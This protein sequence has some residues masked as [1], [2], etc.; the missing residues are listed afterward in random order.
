MKNSR[1]KKILI[2]I[3]ST[4]VIIIASFCIYE[5][6]TWNKEYYKNE[7]NIAIPIFIY[8]DIV[9][10][11]SDVAYDYMQTTKKV[12][13]EQISGLLKWGY[14]VIDYDDLIAYDK[15]EKKLPKHVCLIDFDDGYVG[16]YTIAADI[17]KKYN[18]PVTIFV[19]D[20][21]VGTEG[22]M[23]WDQIREL[24][25]TGLIDINSHGKEHAR[26]NELDSDK[27]V[28]D[29]KLAHSHIEQE[30]GFAVTK[31]FTYPYGLNSNDIVNKL[32]EEG[33]VQNF[34]DNKINESKNLNMSKLHRCYPLEDSIGKILLKIQYRLIRYG[35]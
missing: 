7:K 17:I 24:K 11:E 25:K 12:F 30:L 18:I 28:E 10:N 35:E 6:V 14:K 31:V 21:L 3:I 15:G 16:N 26:F 19:V 5:K 34:T 9:E 20:N 33:F 27:A 8:H 1:N 2:Y 32:E 13:E 23:T 4:I 22:Y 29:V